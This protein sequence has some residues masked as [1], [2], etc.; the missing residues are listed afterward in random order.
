MRQVV[1]DRQY[2]DDNDGETGPL[3]APPASLERSTDGDE[4]VSGHQQHDP[5]GRRLGSGGQRPDVALDE[6][7]PARQHAVQLVDNGEWLNDEAGGQVERV[8][9][10]ESLQQPRRRVGLVWIESKHRHRQSVTYTS[11]TSS[12]PC[13]T[14]YDTTRQV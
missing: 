3:D 10:G 13:D 11:T 14:T 12:Q 1:D 8:D 4:A 6:R 2:E 9:C 7:E 5:D